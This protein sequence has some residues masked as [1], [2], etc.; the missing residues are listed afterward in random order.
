MGR[1]PTG[2]PGLP[3]K[4]VAATPP[5][6]RPVIGAPPP[7]PVP[8]NNDPLAAARICPSC[9]KEGRVVSNHLGTNVFCGPCK[10]HWPIASGSKQEMIIPN[11]PRGLRK[12]TRIE[13]DWDM[14]F[15]ED[16]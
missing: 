6:G 10:R 3:H 4:R 15:D 8:V 12:E 1:K 16:L 9:G 7:V 11:L 2:L 13:P 5:R 14:A